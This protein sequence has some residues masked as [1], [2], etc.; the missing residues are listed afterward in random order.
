MA[1]VYANVGGR[2]LTKIIALH[3][4][5]QDELEK[6]VQ[7]GAHKAEADLLEHRAQGHAFIEVESG[8]VDHYLILNDERGLKAALSIEYGRKAKSDPETGETIPGS[9][10]LFILHKALGVPGKSG[11]NAKGGDEFE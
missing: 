4:T 11:G 5:V 3:Q 10:G 7:V 8:E 6:Q 1:E 2:K 9:R